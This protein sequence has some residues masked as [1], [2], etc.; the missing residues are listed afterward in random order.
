MTSYTGENKTAFSNF[1]GSRGQ[2]EIKVKNNETYWRQTRHIL[3]NILTSR[4][5]VLPV[6][7]KKVRLPF[8]LKDVSAQKKFGNLQRFLFLGYVYVYILGR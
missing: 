2:F 7:D 4:K 3:R 8:P 1:P 6:P 5:W